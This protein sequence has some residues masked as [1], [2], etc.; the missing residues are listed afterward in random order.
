MYMN[1]ALQARL[2]NKQT[3]FQSNSFCS[4][5][6]VLVLVLAQNMNQEPFVSLLL[7]PTGQYHLAASQCKRF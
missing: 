4:V 1:A 3:L 5:V 2:A 6:P 7:R